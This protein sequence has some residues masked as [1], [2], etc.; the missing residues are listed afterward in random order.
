MTNN[1]E[2]RIRGKAFLVL[3]EK[4]YRNGSVKDSLTDMLTD[5]RHACRQAKIDFDACVTISEMHHE[6]ELATKEEGR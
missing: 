6:E 2:R 1:T 3:A 5:L 4:T